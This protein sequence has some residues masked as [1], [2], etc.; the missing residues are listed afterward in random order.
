MSIETEIAALSSMPFGQARTSAAE[1]IVR[2][3]EAEGPRQ[4]LAWA[5]SNLVEAYTFSGSDDQ[6]IVPFTRMLRLWDESPELF[7]E[8]DRNAMFWEYKWIADSI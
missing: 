5:L 2:K 1:A 7:D 8:Q 6:A 3:V 4:H